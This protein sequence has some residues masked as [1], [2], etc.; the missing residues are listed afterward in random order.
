MGFYRWDDLTGEKNKL[1]IHLFGTWLSLVEHYLGVVGVVGSNPAVP[2]IILTLVCVNNMLK[3]IHQI[4]VDG[5]VFMYV[6]FI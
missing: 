1:I 2:T 4:V 6:V 5:F 3:A